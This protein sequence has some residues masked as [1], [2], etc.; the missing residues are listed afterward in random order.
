MHREKDLGAQQ[1]DRQHARKQHFAAIIEQF[2]D[3]QSR[4]RSKIINSMEFSQDVF[5]PRR[6]RTSSEATSVSVTLSIV[7]KY[8]TAQIFN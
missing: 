3:N 8:G 1:A 7:Q 5:S 6:M 2:D 4:G